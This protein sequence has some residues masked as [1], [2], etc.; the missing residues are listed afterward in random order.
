MYSPPSLPRHEVSLSLLARRMRTSRKLTTCQGTSFI[1]LCP[2]FIYSFFFALNFIGLPDSFLDQER[3]NPKSQ[4]R[5]NTALHVLVPHY[6]DYFT[7]PFQYLASHLTFCL[8]LPTQYLLSYLP[9]LILLRYP[10]LPVQ[11]PFLFA[12]HYFPLPRTRR[13]AHA[14]SLEPQLSSLLGQTA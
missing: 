12:Y 2:F 11:L 14:A 13:L 10:L 1:Y 5:N 7:Y 8:T 3:I 9:P 4:I 6:L